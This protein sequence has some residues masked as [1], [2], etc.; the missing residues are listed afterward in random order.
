MADPDGDDDVG[1]NRPA[2]KNKVCVVNRSSGR[3]ARSD[4]S[5]RNT[6]NR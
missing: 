5:V 3:C 4:F 2:K 6:A 1:L